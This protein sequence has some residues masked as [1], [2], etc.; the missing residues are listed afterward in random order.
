MSAARRNILF[1][2]TD[3]QRRDSLG[4]YGGPGAQT[5]ALDGLAASGVRFDQWYTPT[6]ICTPARATLLTGQLPFRHKLLANA[7]RNVG[8][9]EDLEPGTFS[10][11]R[12]LRDAGYNVGLMG[13]WHVGEELTAGDFGFDGPHFV[14]WHNQIDHP[15]YQAYLA[16]HDYPPY[17]IH[18]RIRGTLPNG[19]PGNL[20]AARLRQP[21]EA[22]FE[23]YLADRTIEMLRRY[24]E[25]AKDGQP[26]FLALHFSG[27]HLPYVI[28]DEWFDLIDVE[29]VELPPSTLET[30]EGKPPIQRNYS[31]LWTFDSLTPEQSRKLIAVSRG[32][33]ALL[34]HEIGRVLA[35][36][37]ELGL[38]DD[39]A[40]F[41]TSDHGE[42]T[43]AH[44]LHDKGPAMYDDIYRTCG[45]LRVPGEAPGVVSEEFVTLTDCTA[46]ILDLAGVDPSGAVDSR[47]LLPLATDGERPEWDDAVVGEFHGHHFPYPQRM[48]RTSTHKLIVNPE[49]VCELYDLVRDP[50][51]LVNV[52]RLPEYEQVRNALM[53]DLYERLKA[54]GD[55]FYHWMTTAYPVGGVAYDPSM[56]GL[57]AASYPAPESVPVAVTGAGVA[58]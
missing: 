5:P 40:V 26:F 47:S 51:E 31:D 56:G 19:G 32:Y 20:L 39:T 57:D 38:N 9:I 2:M 21:T 25:G 16:E 24:A 34:D 3:Q 18:D 15:D 55:K 30:F 23:H 43:G 58:S 48:I 10:F 35:V 1:L 14:G 28:P 54:R 52:Y 6:A 36:L 50:H 27:P 29:T 42:F 13:K 33:V 44:R 53:A 41:F 45:L 49:S 22:T 11:S 8:Y 4:C 37:E 46:T 17:E 7:E 12:A